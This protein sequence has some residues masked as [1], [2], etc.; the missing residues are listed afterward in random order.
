ME[1]EES[2]GVSASRRLLE[3]E[4]ENASVLGSGGER[5]AWAGK[6]FMSHDLWGTVAAFELLRAA[7]I[8]I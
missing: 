3:S 8:R 7:L 5:L 6:G 2:L 1:L 4:T